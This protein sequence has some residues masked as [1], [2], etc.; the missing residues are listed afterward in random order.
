MNSSVNQFQFIESDFP[1]LPQVPFYCPY[2]DPDSDEPQFITRKEYTDFCRKN[3]HKILDDKQLK[4]IGEQHRI[5]VEEEKKQRDEFF[6]PYDNL[7]GKR[8]QEGKLI[9]RFNT[10]AEYEAHCIERAAITGIPVEILTN[11]QLRDLAKRWAEEKE[12]ALLQAECRN[13][14]DYLEQQWWDNC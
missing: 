13:Y 1:G 14:L 5:A 11:Q 7:E 3:N 4:E 8:D 10:R 12:L 6:C 9:P 2:V